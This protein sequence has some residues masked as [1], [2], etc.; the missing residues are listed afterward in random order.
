MSGGVIISFS[1][2]APAYNAGQFTITREAHPTELEYK[3]GAASYI[4]TVTL[5]SGA[6][7]S[8]SGLL[9]R[10]T[11]RE[12]LFIPY[13]PG[14]RVY[15]FVPSDLAALQAFINQYRASAV[16]AEF[17]TNVTLADVSSGGDPSAVVDVQGD[18]GTDKDYIGSISAELPH[19]R[20]GGPIEM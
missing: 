7:V 10:N 12:P 18:D 20:D 16:S 19:W 9:V 1:T 13:T 6:T 3:G 15:A 4:L 5:T 17:D 11:S 8:H 2:T 14:H